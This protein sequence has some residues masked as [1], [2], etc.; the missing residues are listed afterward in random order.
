M[1]SSA[2]TEQFSQPDIFSCCSKYTCFFGIHLSS[3]LFLRCKWGISAEG[4]GCCSETTVYKTLLRVNFC[5]PSQEVGWCNFWWQYSIRDPTRQGAGT[6]TGALHPYT[7]GTAPLP[8][9]LT[10][11]NNGLPKN[12]TRPLL[13]NATVSPTKWLHFA[14]PYW[15]LLPL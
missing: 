14:F 6:G 9:Q 11:C 5:A 15:G 7:W 2:R 13:L 8:T 4:N 10:R 3:H 12:W 1:Q